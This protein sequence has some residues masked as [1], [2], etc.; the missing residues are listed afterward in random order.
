MLNGVLIIRSS[1]LPI[2][3]SRLGMRVRVHTYSG[4]VRK[5]WFPSIST[6]QPAF[7]AVSVGRK[8]R[9]KARGKRGRGREGRERGKREGRERGGKEG[10]ERGERGEGRR[11]ERGEREGKGSI[12]RNWC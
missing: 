3:T 5:V 12:P 6:T 11:E 4:G 9:E 10:R 7:I 8:R 1:R 2:W